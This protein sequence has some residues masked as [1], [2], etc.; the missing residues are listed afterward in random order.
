MEADMGW[1]YFIPDNI[2]VFAGEGNVHSAV[3]ATACLRMSGGGTIIDSTQSE[4]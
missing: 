2:S 3:G 4:M 1:T